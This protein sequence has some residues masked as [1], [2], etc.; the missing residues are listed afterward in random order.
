[1]EVM[2]PADEIRLALGERMQHEK[3]AQSEPQRGDPRLTVSAL[4]EDVGTLLTH[5]TAMLEP[6][7]RRRRKPPQ[8]DKQDTTVMPSRLSFDAVDLNRDGVVTRDELEQAMRGAGSLEGR[9]EGQD[10][11]PKPRKRTPRRRRRGETSAHCSCC[12]RLLLSCACVVNRT[13][14]DSSLF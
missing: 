6:R 10:A 11:P 4:E 5:E 1:M 2:N 8:Q 7:R 12:S 3:A 13:H 9:G 14:P